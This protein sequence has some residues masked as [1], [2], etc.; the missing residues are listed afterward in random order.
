[1]D[2]IDVINNECAT[3]SDVADLIFILM[4]QLDNGLER[5]VNV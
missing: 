3:M 1:M 5:D 4:V 2:I